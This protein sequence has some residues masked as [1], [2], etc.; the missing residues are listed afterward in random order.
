MRDLCHMSVGVIL[1]LIVTVT[2]G[3][4]RRKQFQ[5]NTNLE[6]KGKINK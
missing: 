4:P 1:T 2:K 3:I 5:A 6:K